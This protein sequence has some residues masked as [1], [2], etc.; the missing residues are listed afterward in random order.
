MFFKYSLIYIRR[1]IS[2]AADN[3]N[4]AWHGDPTSLSVNVIAASIYPDNPIVWI[5]PD[6]LASKIE[7]YLVN[8]VSITER[9]LAGRAAKR[10]SLTPQIRRPIKQGDEERGAVLYGVG[11]IYLV[12]T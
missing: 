12:S 7:H 3:P 8:K 5:T 10:S 9:G 6:D 11:W 2:S 4:A 1:V